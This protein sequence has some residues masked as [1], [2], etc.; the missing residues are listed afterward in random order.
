MP[1]AIVTIKGGIGNQL[2]QYAFGESIKKKWN[3][4][5]LYNIDWFYRYGLD[6]PRELALLKLVDLNYIKHSKKKEFLQSPHISKLL[7]QFSF[8]HKTEFRS[9]ESFDFFEHY[10]KMPSKKIKKIFFNG[11][12]QSS[13][14]FQL[15][16]HDLRN[17]L[18]AYKTH[19]KKSSLFNNIKNAKNST[20]LHIRRG[21]YISNKAA[22]N[23]FDTCSLDYYKNAINNINKLAGE[24]SK[25]FIFSDDIEWAKDNI[26]ID[27]NLIYVDSKY[28]LS[29][30]D[31]LFLMSIC[32]NHIIANSTYSWWGAWIGSSKAGI[33]ICPKNW[34]KSSKQPNA[35]FPEKWISINNH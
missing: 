22:K 30:L 3:C 4:E 21:D 31:E 8:L 5:V 1:K 12:W 9:E 6:T 13:K 7:N 25:F 18:L 23:T 26:N 19:L 14:Y 16:E 17:K 20:S 11:Y 34:Y 15:I 2:F 24:E 27:N 33:T 28:N 35:L 29:D 10:Q 32:K